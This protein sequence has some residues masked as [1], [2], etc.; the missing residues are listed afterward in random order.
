MIY[1]VNHDISEGKQIERPIA[2]RLLYVIKNSNFTMM[3]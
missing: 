3:C 2:S 1:N